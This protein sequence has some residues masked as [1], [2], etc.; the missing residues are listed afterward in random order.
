LEGRVE[1]EGPARDT[2]KFEIALPAGYEVDD[3]PP[4]MDVD[5]SFASYYSKTEK[6]GNVLQYTRTFEIKELSVPVNKIEKLKKLYRIIASDEGNTAVLKP[7]PNL[8]GGCYV[9]SSEQ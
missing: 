6:N 5:Y 7:K 9:C 2:D 8:V 3:L 1:F 4:P